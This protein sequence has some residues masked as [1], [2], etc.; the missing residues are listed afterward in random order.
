M[1]RDFVYYISQIGTMS[2][3][4]VDI[5]EGSCPEQFHNISLN[6]NLFDFAAIIRNLSIFFG[7]PLEDDITSLEFLCFCRDQP[8]PEF[9]PASGMHAVLFTS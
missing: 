6:H 3:A 2:I 4:H 8:Y 1:L 5:W 7:C 9:C